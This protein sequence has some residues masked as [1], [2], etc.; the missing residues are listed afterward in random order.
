MSLLGRLAEQFIYGIIE[1]IVCLVGQL[2][3]VAAACHDGQGLHQL[4]LFR[5]SFNKDMTTRGL[6]DIIDLIIY[7]QLRARMSGTNTSITELFG[8]AQALMCHCDAN[9]TIK[10]D[11]PNKQV[12]QLAKALGAKIPAYIKLPVFRYTTDMT[13]D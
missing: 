4:R 1:D 2:A 3:T 7:L 9:K 10:V 13:G 8:N 11:T 6:L 5:P 12:K